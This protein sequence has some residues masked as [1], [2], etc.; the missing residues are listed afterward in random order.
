MTP[1]RFI[2]LALASALF[3]IGRGE[4]VSLPSC[5]NV[6]PPQ[7]ILSS[8]RTTDVAVTAS[9]FGVVYAK[10][11]DIAFVAL[12][13]S[14]GV[15]N[16]STFT[17]RLIHEIPLPSQYLSTTGATGVALSSN[18]RHVLVTAFS[19]ALFVVDAAK[20]VIGSPDAVIGVLTGSAA[21]GHNAI[22]VT[23]TKDDEYAFVSQEDG[24][25]QTS[26]RGTIE[27]FKLQRRGANGTISGTYVGYLVL[28]D[29]VVGTPLSHDGRRL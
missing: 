14:L 15:L 25:L 18:G 6:A 23:V 3:W 5:Q 10:D 26:E 11:R 20:A 4:G 8:V 13:T 16:T 7:K 17:P 2:C 22:E 12:N 28:G 27:V 24:S 1:N 9:P 19:A 21:A 29:L